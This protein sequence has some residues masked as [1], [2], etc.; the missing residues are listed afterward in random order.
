MKPMLRLMRD[1]PFFELDLVAC[2]M[3]T[4]PRF[5]ETVR[6]AEADFDVSKIGGITGGDRPQVLGYI[7]E[8]FAR[9]M[10]RKRPDLL[11]LYGDRGE[12]LAAATVATEMCI[13]IAHLQGGDRSGTMDNRRRHAISMLSDLHFV[14]NEQSRNNLYGIIHGIHVVGDSHL[15]PIFDGDF[16]T[17]D[18]IHSCYL[19][20][21][22]D[23]PIY[24]ILFHPDPT[25]PRDDNLIFRNIMD[26]VDDLERQFVII[27]PCSDP[28][29][30]KLVKAINWFRGHENIQIHKN[31]PSRTF[32]GLMNCADMIIGNSSAGIIEAPYMDLVALNIGNRQKGRLQSNNV[33]NCGHTIQEI[34]SCF[35]LAEHLGRQHY[36]YE[37]LYG[38]GAT[39]KRIVNILKEWKQ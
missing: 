16:E 17:M 26:A 28:G 23:K 15:D 6:E 9:R 32:L 30:E 12:S 5:G 21:D 3:H 25:D 34:K 36:P 4:D 24:I 35:E 29:W 11:M 31:L 19:D 18:Y 22:P 39:G 33:I 13:P 2:D 27:Y 14:S 10:K 20:L 38:N 37:K 8:V 7:A 1:D